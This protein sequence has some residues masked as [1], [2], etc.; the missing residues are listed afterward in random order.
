M[1]V[2]FIGTGWTDR[3]QIST[4]QLAGL[5]PYAISSRSKTKGQE[6]VEKFNLKVN[7]THWKE[8]I[9]DDNVDIV[10]ICTP[11]YTHF[12]MAS[13]A[14]KNNKIVICQAPFMS[15][16]EV[17]SLIELN[18]KHTKAKIYIDFELRF[19]PARQK[20][21]EMLEQNF[22][23][24][25][26]HSEITYKKNFSLPEDTI[27][28]W[29]HDLDMGGGML[30]IVGDALID[31]AGFLLGDIKSV[32]TSTFTLYDN[33]KSGAELKKATGDDLARL[34]LESKLNGEIDIVASSIHGENKGMKVVI[35]GTEG[36]LK[37]D[38]EDRLWHLRNDEEIWNPIGLKSDLPKEMSEDLI[39][40]P[41]AVGTYYFGKSL[42]LE[43]A[44]NLSKACDL[45]QALKMQEILDAAHK[46]DRLK[47]PIL[48]K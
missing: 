33:K 30:N 23:G 1:N 5:T 14:I 43:L 42:A 31:L 11:T 35:R 13:M 34:I 45:K 46:S 22:I 18:K 44:D 36:I 9:S 6:L 29:E 47:K 10:S 39:N 19:T 7:Y 38:S 16:Q 2:G 48:I 26:F 37:I 15:T 28:S 27:W 21:K 3:V 12:D 41:Y 32:Y 40:Y 20:L 4:Y 24:R 25:V 8:L 17:Q